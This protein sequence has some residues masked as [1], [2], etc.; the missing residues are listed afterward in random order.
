LVITT[1][2]IFL[3]IDPEEIGVLAPYKAQARAIRE[4]LKVANLSDISVGSVE[5][6]QGQVRCKLRIEDGPY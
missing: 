4:L 2:L 1:L 3:G 5:Q 6:F